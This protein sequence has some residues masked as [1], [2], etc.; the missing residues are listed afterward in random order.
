M[1]NGRGKEENNKSNKAGKKNRENNTF[2]RGIILLTIEFE[3]LLTFDWCHFTTHVQKFIQICP[4]M[5]GELSNRHIEIPE[6]LSTVVISNCTCSLCIVNYHKIC[7]S[8]R[9]V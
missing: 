8:N 1:K 3:F 7:P 4:N 5:W 6:I 2:S 9:Q